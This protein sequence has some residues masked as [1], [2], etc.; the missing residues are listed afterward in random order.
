MTLSSL[1]AISSPEMMLVPRERGLVG[2]VYRWEGVSIHTQIDI[3]E[4]AT[5]D[6]T[7]DAVLVPH[8]EVLEGRKSALLHMPNGGP[9]ATGVGK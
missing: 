6:F 9:E 2:I 5:A 1:M 3:A 7:A 8:A 4:A